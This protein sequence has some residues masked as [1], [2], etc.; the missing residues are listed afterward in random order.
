MEKAECNELVRKIKDGDEAAFD[1]LYVELRP[2][3]C[4]FLLPLLNYS[5]EDVQDVIQRTFVVV[6]DKV[7]RLTLI[8]DNTFG[9]IFGI[10]KNIARSRPKSALLETPTDFSE[11]DRLVSLSNEEEWSDILTIRELF[12]KLKPIEQQM[13]SLRFYDKC[14][15]REI[16]LILD[17]PES[18]LKRKFERLLERIRK[19]WGEGL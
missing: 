18:T 6:I 2:M 9:W 19:E 13:L 17:M 3:L 16:A 7:K 11:N 8:S 12:R 10:A 15:F 1:R 4:S 14:K 5:A